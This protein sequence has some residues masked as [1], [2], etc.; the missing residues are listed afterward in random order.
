MKDSGVPTLDVPDTYYEVLQ[1][2]VPNI[3]E[4][5]TTLKK[6]KILADGDDE[7][8]LLQLFSQNAIDPIFYEFIQRK[9][10]WGFG[11]GNFQALFEAIE[12]D[13]RRRGVL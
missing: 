5:M 3:T 1:D 10:H 13:Q 11:E 6:L 7:G 12:R 2:R 4:D 9:N 8:Y